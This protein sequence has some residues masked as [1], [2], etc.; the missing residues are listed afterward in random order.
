VPVHTSD[1]R[2][3]LRLRLLIDQKEAYSYQF[4][5]DWLKSANANVDAIANR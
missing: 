1:W 3:R 4:L 5:S 2:L